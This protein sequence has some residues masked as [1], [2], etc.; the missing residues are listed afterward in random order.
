MSIRAIRNRLPAV[1]ARECEIKDAAVPFRLF[2]S[3]L[4]VCRGLRMTVLTWGV[5]SCQEKDATF[6]D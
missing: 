5:G 3:I 2:V 6:F 4:T 1:Y